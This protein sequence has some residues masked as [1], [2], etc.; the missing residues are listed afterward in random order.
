MEREKGTAQGP[1]TFGG[2]KSVKKL[3]DHTVVFEGKAFVSFFTDSNHQQ[4]ELVSVIVV[5]LTA[6][7]YELRSP[8]QQPGTR[9]LITSI[10]GWSISGAILSQAPG[11]TRFSAR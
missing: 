2:G 10:G 11:V 7:M 3:M 5:L 4:L 8:K 1:A 6:G 9:V